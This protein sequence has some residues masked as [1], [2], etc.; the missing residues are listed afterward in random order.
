[1]RSVAEGHPSL[2]TPR[3][4]AK[5]Y[6]DLKHNYIQLLSTLFPNALSIDAAKEAPEKTD[7]GDID[8]IIID[9]GEVDWAKVA[10]ELGVVAWVNR[11]TDTKPACSSRWNSERESTH[12]IRPGHGKRPVATK[13]FFGGR[14][15][16]V[17]PN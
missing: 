15:Q 7:F 3:M 13:S 12:Q 2:D 4:D 16:T 5:T 1:M 14:R 17:R 8:I 6:Q 9:D 10:A 11:G